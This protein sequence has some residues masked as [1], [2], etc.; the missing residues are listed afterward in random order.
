MNKEMKKYYQEIYKMFP[1]HRKKEKLYFSELK[2]QLVELANDKENC[3]YQ[4]CVEE[5]GTPKE[6]VIAYY[7]MMDSKELL[8]ELN[9]KKM[10]KIFLGFM[11]IALIICTVF[12]FVIKTDHLKHGK[13]I[14][15][16][17]KKMKSKFLRRNENE[18]NFIS[19]LYDFC[20]FN[21]FYSTKFARRSSVRKLLYY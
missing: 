12:L 10:I 21:V 9:K 1:I 2:E 20:I 16:Y 5:F 15:Q 8:N 17:M 19:N 18:E 6:I 7:E 13:K 11:V 4:D 3:T 14:Y